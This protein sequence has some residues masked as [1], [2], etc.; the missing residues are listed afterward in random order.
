VRALVVLEVEQYDYFTLGSTR[1][2]DVDPH[3]ALATRQG[4]EVAA[5]LR[6]GLQ[7]VYSTLGHACAT[8]HKVLME[9][10]VQQKSF[11]LNS[12]HALVVP[13]GGSV[14]WDPSSLGTHKNKRMW[15]TQM[16]ESAFSPDL[17]CCAI[18]TIRPSEHVRADV[19]RV[20]VGQLRPFVPSD[21]ADDV[22]METV[23]R[24]VQEGKHKGRANKRHRTLEDGEIDTSQVIQGQSKKQRI[25]AQLGPDRELTQ[26]GRLVFVSEHLDSCGDTTAGHVHEVLEQRFCRSEG[27]KSR[28]VLTLRVLRRERTLDC[29]APDVEAFAKGFKR[30]WESTIEA[31]DDARRRNLLL[32]LDRHHRTRGTSEPYAVLRHLLGGKASMAKEDAEAIAREMAEVVADAGPDDR[33]DDQRDDQRVDQR[34]DPSVDHGDDYRV[35]AFGPM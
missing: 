22:A 11:Y 5:K 33:R 27:T 4:A 12:Y 13:Q 28:L 7:A 18:A 29:P 17:A 34:D 25:R 3:D 8:V 10:G 32:G 21:A 19:V 15:H 23:R 30:A 24:K 2:V 6:K 14:P 9:L 35:W 16:E 20:P 31:K 26:V 1:V